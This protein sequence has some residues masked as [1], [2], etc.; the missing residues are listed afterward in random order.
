MK[1]EHYNETIFGYDTEIR[2][3][4]EEID[5]YD[6]RNNTWKVTELQQELREVQEKRSSFESKYQSKI[7]YEAK[8]TAQKTPVKVGKPTI[9]KSSTSKV[10]EKQ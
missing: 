7:V 5:Y 6:D 10:A 9:G 2:R 4:S 1:Q 8:P 3:I